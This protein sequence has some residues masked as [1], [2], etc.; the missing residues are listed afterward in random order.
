MKELIILH[1][2]GILQSWGEN[3]KW[4]KRSTSGFP[5][6]SGI[7]GI[8]SCALGLNRDD[9]KIED[10]SSR[11]VIGVRADRRGTIIS[12]YQTVQGMP[13]LYTADGKKRN[14]NTLVTPREYL[15]DSSFTVVIDADSVLIDEI[16]EAFMN[17]IWPVYLYPR[18]NIIRERLTLS[19]Y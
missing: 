6:K 5:T 1:F 8:I 13:D 14:N 17:P 18:T 19:L 15:C 10:I 9:P 4:N 16:A 7:V 12:D 2:E 3:S 11:I